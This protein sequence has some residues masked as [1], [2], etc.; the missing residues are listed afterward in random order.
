MVVANAPQ[1]ESVSLAPNHD[2]RLRADCEKLAGRWESRLGDECSLIVREPYVIAGNTNEATLVAWYEQTIQP[3]TIAMQDSYVKVKPD[4]PITVLLFNSKDSYTEYADTLFGDRGI[5]IYGY[6][7]PNEKTLVMNIATGGGTL[8]HEL[9]H[10]LVDFDFPKIPDWFNE[11]FASLHEQCRFTEI[12]GKRGIEGFENWRLAGLQ[13]SIRDE[14][15]PS[16][17]AL[18]ENKAFRGENVGRNYA[19]ARYFCM[20]LQKQGKLRSFYEAFRNGY[21]QDK[22]GLTMAKACFPDQ[23]WEEIDAEYRDWVMTLRY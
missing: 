21:E 6:Y 4:R 2:D 9:T 5:S 13:K 10:A 7:K 1:W 14:Q 17:K 15:L 16:L 22:T 8:V 19:Q 3:A 18:I 12:D 11:G 20:Y 23:T